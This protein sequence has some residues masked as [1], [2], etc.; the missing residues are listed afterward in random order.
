M[1]VAAGR[2][3]SSRGARRMNRS[4]LRHSTTWQCPSFDR[5]VGME[6]AAS[7]IGGTETKITVR[8]PF[9]D[10]LEIFLPRGVHRIGVA[11]VI[12]QESFNVGG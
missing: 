12:G 2:L 7:R 11:E 4:P 10:L 3:D 9:P 8:F 6:E 1:G 5:G